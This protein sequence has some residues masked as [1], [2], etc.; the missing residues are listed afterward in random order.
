MDAI[1]RV[2]GATPAGMAAAA[3]RPAASGN[4][5]DLPDAAAPAVAGATAAAGLGGLIALQEAEGER[6]SERE[7]RRRGRDLLAELAALQRD[8]LG[9]GAAP[10]RLDRLTALV[11]SLPVPADPGLRDT[12]Q[13]VA[14][15]ARIELAHY[16]RA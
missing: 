12:L 5:F 3:P 2:T 4:R 6:V 8:L 16:A 11:E 15:R 14:L 7:A 9:E 13:A 1:Q 10:E